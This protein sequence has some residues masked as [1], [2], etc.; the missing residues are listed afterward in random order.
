MHRI[1]KFFLLLSL[2]ASTVSSVTLISSTSSFSQIATPELSPIPSKISSSSSLGTNIF[3]PHL[4][5]GHTYSNSVLPFGIQMSDLGN[6]QALSLAQGMGPG[7][8]RV[9]LSWSRLEPSNTT[10]EGFEWSVYDGGFAAAAQAG[11][12]PIVS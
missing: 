11:I 9:G 5:K 2:V 12:Q 8:V 1:G 4:Q 3:L 6:S 7:W 10:S